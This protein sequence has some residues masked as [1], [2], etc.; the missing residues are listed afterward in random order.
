MLAG[1]CYEIVPPL[2]V[3][4]RTVTVGAE[5][6]RV[7]LNGR[8]LCGQVQF[9][10]EPPTDFVS[11]CHCRSCRL[12]HGAPLVTWTSVPPERF[13]MGTGQECLRSYHSSPEVQWQFCGNCG[14]SLFYRATHSPGQVYVAAAALDGLDRLPQSHVSFEERLP[15]FQV[16]DELPCFQEKSQQQFPYPGELC[17]REVE[18]RDLHAFFVHQLDPQAHSLAGLP[19]RGWPEFRDHW[20]AKILSDSSVCKRTITVD[21]LPAGHILAWNH[22]SRRRVGYWLD[23]A[24]WG[25]GLASRALQVFLL[26][27]AV[28]P[29]E[30]LVARGNAASR[31]VLEKNG[32][33]IQPWENPQEYMLCLPL[34]DGLPG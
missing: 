14:S 25:R 26:E 12:S 24:Y 3:F 29:L 17:L 11:H 9:R 20:Q 27:E 21:G 6:E 8:C 5:P 19:P 4:G 34:Q 18:E 1:R 10:L 15:W 32:F 23:R 30:A 31:R 16:G 33:H 2:G 7:S 13:V 22:E 28:R